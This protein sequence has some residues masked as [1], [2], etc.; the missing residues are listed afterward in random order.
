MNLRR[1]ALPECFPLYQLVIVVPLHWWEIKIKKA[2][3]VGSV[4]WTYE[5]PLPNYNSLTA[6]MTLFGIVEISLQGYPLDRVIYTKENKQPKQI[7]PTLV[8]FWESL[9][10][11][12]RIDKTKEEKLTTILF[13]QYHFGWVGDH[14]DQ[15]HMSNN[16]LWWRS[17]RE[18]EVQLIVNFKHI[19][20]FGMVQENMRMEF[21]WTQRPK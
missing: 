6:V 10:K 19:I 17:H 21:P 13:V 12:E 7:H 16:I 14:D 4:S 9:N 2:K 3:K 1:Q 8:K 20:T 18:K 15:C 5:I 11:I